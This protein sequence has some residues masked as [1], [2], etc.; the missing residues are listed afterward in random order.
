[1]TSAKFL[2]FLTPSPPCQHFGHTVLKSRNLAYCVRIWA[3]PS[4]PLSSDVIC[5]WPLTEEKLLMNDSFFL[6]SD[7]SGNRLSN[8]YAYHEFEMIGLFV[9]PGIKTWSSALRGEGGVGPKTD[10]GGCADFVP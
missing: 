9:G 7:F 4:L 1:M 3:T 2:G 6:T 10:I 5:E 8:S